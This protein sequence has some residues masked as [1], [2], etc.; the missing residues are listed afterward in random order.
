VEPGRIYAGQTGGTK[1]PSGA[2]PS[3]TLRDRIGS[4][5][6]R[7]R[8]RAST[9]RLALAAAL[10]NAL[11]LRPTGPKRLDTDSEDMLS[12]WIRTHLEVAV[13]PFEDRDALKDLEHRVLLELDPPL[14]SKV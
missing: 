13:H 8:I 5:H 7:G 6:L 14:T 1:W 3:T 11:P 4:N 10:R 12:D 2:T 9:F